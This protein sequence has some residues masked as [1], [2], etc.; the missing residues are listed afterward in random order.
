MSLE[1]AKPTQVKNWALKT[2]LW[3]ESEYTLGQPKRMVDAPLILATAELSA[4]GLAALPFI[5]HRLRISKW[6][7]NEALQP[8]GDG[9][10]IGLSLVLPVWNEEKL[11]IQKLDNLASQDFPRENLEL[12]IID[13]AST[14][15]TMTL[16][17]DWL[18]ENP[19][20]FP[21]YQLIQMEQRLGK[22]EAVKRAFNA[23]ADENPVIAMTDADAMVPDTGALKRLASW[24]E[25]AAIGAVGGTPN[26]QTES[27]KAHVKLEQG[28]RNLF[29][30]QRIAESQVDSTPFLEGSLVAFRKKFIDTS[31]LDCGSNADDSQLATMARLNGGRSI[32]DPELLFEEGTP[33]SNSGR[34]QRK[35][36]RAQGLCRH[37]WRNRSSWFAKKHGH[38][39]KILGNQGIMHIF[40]PWL[41]ILALMLGFSRWFMHL[42]GEVSLEGW[43]LILFI[44]EM[45]VLISLISIIVN[46]RIPGL[47]LMQTYL[48]GMFSLLWAHFLILKGKSLHIWEQPERE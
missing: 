31:L 43:I 38:F 10:S 29:T 13:S 14:D 18:K 48:D 8:S 28:Y 23:A 33:S 20:E 30:Q 16:A 26:R 12:I 9:E 44:F 40:A 5:L 37:L 21:N 15:T 6:M 22:S 24:F 27:D 25:D 19:K 39:G 36:R 45:L 3:G 2:N 32:Q 1:S 41:L 35:V 34:R 4:A 46:I 7:Q 47:S 11:I 17:K 42:T